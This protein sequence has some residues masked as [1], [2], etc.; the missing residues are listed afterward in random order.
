[1]GVLLALTKALPRS[2][3]SEKPAGCSAE[4]AT[5]GFEELRAALG[6]APQACSC[7][8]QRVGLP[9]GEDASELRLKCFC[10]L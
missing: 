6:V 5:G 8:T 1:M 7:W 9:W 4:G 10:F 3:A 2:P